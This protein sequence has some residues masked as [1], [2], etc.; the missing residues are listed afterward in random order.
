MVLQEQQKFTRLGICQNQGNVLVEGTFFQILGVQ[1]S[2]K[3][4]S[5]DIVVG[6]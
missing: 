6:E 2:H 5:G 3:N 1:K 4:N